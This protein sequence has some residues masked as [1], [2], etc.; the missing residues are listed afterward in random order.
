MHSK[1]FRG[2]MNSSNLDGLK[3]VPYRES[4][5]TTLLRSSLGGNSYCLMIANV[6]PVADF[7]EEHLSTL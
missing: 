2:K 7:L 6:S 1:S 3:Y 4:K 5:L